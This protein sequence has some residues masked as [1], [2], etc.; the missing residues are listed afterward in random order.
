MKN[1]TLI[2]IITLVIGL[3]VA[4][5]GWIYDRNQ[6]EILK[7]VANEQ[8]VDLSKKSTEIANLEITVAEKEDSLKSKDMVIEEQ[9]TQINKYEK[10]IVYLENNIQEYISRNNKVV[11]KPKE[12]KQYA[13]VSRSRT[14]AKKVLTVNASAYI[15][16]CDTGC[17][18]KTATGYDVR[19]TIRYDGLG[20]IAVDPSVIPLY[21]IVEIEGFSGRY[22]ALDTGGRIKGNKI[23][24]LMSTTKKAKEFGRQDLEVRVL[25]E[26]RK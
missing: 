8:K 22:I 16:M 10:R 26:G 17:T 1:K 20:V 21:S 9:S 5:Y 19:N 15:A 23:D 3:V 4:S 11:E 25:R 18:G 24:I 14:E 13:S 2:L 12:D 7:E 6:N